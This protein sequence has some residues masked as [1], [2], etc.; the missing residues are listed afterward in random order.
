VATSSRVFPAW[1]EEGKV[2]YKVRAHALDPRNFKDGGDVGMLAVRY[3]VQA[4]GEKNTVLRINAVFVEDFRHSVH[5]SN[6]SVEGAEYKD[7]HDHLEAMQLVKES[8]GESAAVHKPSV[9]EKLLRNESPSLP[10]A[11]QPSASLEPPPPPKSSEGQATEPAESPEQHLKN[12]RN[13]VERAVK[14]PGAPLKA[15]P[16]HTASTLASLSSGT[17]VL[18]VIS[19]PYWYGVETHDGQHGWISRDELE[20][21]P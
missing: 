6:G 3:V 2:F 16:F 21:L 4:Q 15:S 20:L 17:E 18:I 12:L 19:T 1:Q 8:P 14:A 9:N 13:Q 5:L 11:S 10:L 7:I